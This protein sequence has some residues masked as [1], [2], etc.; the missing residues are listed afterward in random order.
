MG[1][2]LRELMHFINKE[3]NRYVDECNEQGK[4]YNIN[5][6]LN[7]Y[8]VLGDDEE[9]NGVHLC[10]SFAF[11]TKGEK[12][13]LNDFGLGVEFEDDKNYILLS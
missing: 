9:L 11:L 10:N 1:F 8:I 2:T 6:F 4:Q 5:E 12:Q 13:D 3:I 7:S